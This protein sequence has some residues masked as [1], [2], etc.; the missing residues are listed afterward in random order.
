M[1][2]LSKRYIVFHALISHKLLLTLRQAW[3]SGARNW[4]DEQRKKLANDITNPQLVA[5]GEIIC[6]PS[7]NAC[8]HS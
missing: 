6:L 4:D 8:S 3:V 5:V 1:S 7:M 2:F